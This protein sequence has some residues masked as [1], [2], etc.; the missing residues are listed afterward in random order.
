[1][2]GQ[3]NP[4]G[5]RLRSRLEDGVVVIDYTA[6]EEDVGYR[7][8]VHGGVVMTLMDEVMTWAAI[9][10]AAQSCVMAEM[11]TRYRRPI[12]AGTA[13]RV[14]GRVVRDARRLLQTAGRVLSANGTVLAEAEGKYVPTP[15]GVAALQQ[16]DFVPDPHVI[17]LSELIRPPTAS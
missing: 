8:A 11:T 12:S 15:H 13:L 3:D 5:F 7:H 2:C 16:E 6:R 10:A 9:L 1:V 14:E 4:R 17:P